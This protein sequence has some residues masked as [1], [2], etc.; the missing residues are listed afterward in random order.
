MSIQTADHIIRKI[1]NVL[2][3]NDYEELVLTSQ[4]YHHHDILSF[5]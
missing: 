3:E 1:R 5:Y 4:N 2:A